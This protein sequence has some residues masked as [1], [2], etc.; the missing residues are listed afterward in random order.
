MNFNFTIGC[1]PEIFLRKD[2]KAY[3]AHGV[4]PGTKKEP[5]EVDKGAIQVDGMAV[6]FNTEPAPLQG[7]DGGSFKQFNGNIVS[8]M[9]SLKEG[10]QKYDPELTFNLS[11]VQDFDE[12]TMKAQPPEAVELGCDPDYNAYTLK[13][14]PRPEGAAVNFRTASGHIHI[15][16]GADIPIDH[17]SHMEI[18][19]SFVKYLDATV[20]MFMTLLDRDPRR[21][22]LYGKAGA[23]RPKPYG[24]EYRTPSNLWLAS[25]AKRQAIFD[26]C[27]GAVQAAS[28]GWS[29]EKMTGFHPED[30][31]NIIDTGDFESAG[32]VL[33][34]LGGSF[35]YS[36][37]TWELFQSLMKEEKV[38]A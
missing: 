16:W 21:R 8:V 15:G 31:A 5:F 4:I 1:D 26:L 35:Y 18:C 28:G 23:F 24:V 3:S 11:S 36:K 19:G 22:E 7:N 20:G 30:I 38:A 17:P 33:M 32:K 14:N 6:E 9:K 13:V 27:Q 12:E 10:V 34:K 25:R 2:G 37:G 29:I